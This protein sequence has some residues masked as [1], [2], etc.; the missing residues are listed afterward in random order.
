MV[1]HNHSQ[2]VGRAGIPAVDDDQLE[3][4]LRDINLLA[5]VPTHDGL[6]SAGEMHQ[7]SEGGKCIAEKE[8]SPKL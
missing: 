6:C 5:G 4:V 3:V 7:L 2:E 1:V 8:V